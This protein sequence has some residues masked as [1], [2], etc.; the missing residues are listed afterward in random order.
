MELVRQQ[1]TIRDAT[2]NKSKAKIAN[3]CQ[4]SR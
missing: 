1:M 2:V 3:V 4:T